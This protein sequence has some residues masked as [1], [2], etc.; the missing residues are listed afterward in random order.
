M[1]QLCRLRPLH[2]GLSPA[3]F[4]GLQWPEINESAHCQCW[5]M[6]LTELTPGHRAVLYNA[7]QEV[8]VVL[9]VFTSHVVFSV[10]NVLCCHMLNKIEEVRQRLKCTALALD[11]KN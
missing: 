7:L 8:M 9:S 2:S 1:E 5:K 10:L 6:L 4:R 11:C 3:V